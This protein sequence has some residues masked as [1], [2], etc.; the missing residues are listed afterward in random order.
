MFV[1]E[2]K[3]MFV[4]LVMLHRWAYRDLR[5]LSTRAGKEPFVYDFIILL[6][7]KGFGDRDTREPGICGP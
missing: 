1:S 6:E 3:M 4:T 5:G 2:V 7:T